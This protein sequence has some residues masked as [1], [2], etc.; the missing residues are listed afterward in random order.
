M[1]LLLRYGSVMTVTCFTSWSRSLS[2]NSAL[3]AAILQY[4]EGLAASMLLG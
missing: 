4:A 1:H 3:I 2:Q